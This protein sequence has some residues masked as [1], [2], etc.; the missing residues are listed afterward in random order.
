MR[1]FIVNSFLIAIPFMIWGLFII[2]VDPFNYFNLRLFSNESKKSA[3]DLNQLMYRTVDY[4]KSPC[5]N[6]LIGDSRTELLP[7][8]LLQEIDNRKYK[9]MNTSGAKLNEIFELFYL[10]NEHQKIKR[11]VIGINFNMFNKYGYQDRVSGLKRVL[12]NPLM[13]VYNK[14]VADAAYITSKYILTKKGVDFKPPMSVDEFWK[15]SI[16]TKAS[17]WYGKYEFPD[18][19]HQ[20]L[21][22]FD[23]YAKEKGIDVT[24]IIA[25]HHEEFHDRL[26]G[27]GLKEEEQR[28]K[29]IM[30][31]LHA[32]VYDYDYPNAVTAAKN[33]FKDPVHYNDSIG[34]LIVKEI[35]NKKLLIGKEL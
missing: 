30:A 23:N 22:D 32:K 26:V 8:E 29:K 1:R 35:W 21:L 27:F 20:E 34:N 9:K 16:E 5:E 2:A 15:W 10:A 31:G 18:K 4:I 3:E 7:I 25:P 14:D 12:D 13:Y 28:F 19:L 24:F 33:N 6:I 17:D 11:V